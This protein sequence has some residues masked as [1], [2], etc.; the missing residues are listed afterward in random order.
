MSEAKTV[1]K[2]TG[3][4]ATRSIYLNGNLLNPSRSLKVRNHSPDGFCWGYGGS[5]PSQLALAILLEVID[6]ETACANYQQFKWEVIAKLTQSYFEVEI[7]VEPYC[8][9]MFA[10]ESKQ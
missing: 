9:S 3:D 10:E 2:L 5:G 8:K 6:K 1:I 7:D 4:I